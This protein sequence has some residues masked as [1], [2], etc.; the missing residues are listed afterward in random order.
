MGTIYI[1]DRYISIYRLYMR[2][3]YRYLS[4]VGIYD[5]YVIS[6]CRYHIYIYLLH[7]YMY[8]YMI[9]MTDID[10]IPEF[11]LRETLRLVLKILWL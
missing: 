9:F 11:F 5:I 4:I 2:S 7:R 10:K 3:I 6:I 8:T 1:Y